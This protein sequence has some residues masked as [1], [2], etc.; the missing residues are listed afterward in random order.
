[1]K[2]IVRAAFVASL[3]L[4]AAGTATLMASTAADADETPKV[5]AKVGKPLSDAQKAI[6][7]NDFQ[8]ALA[9]VK[10]AQAVPDRTPFE[11]YEIN[12]FLAAV[13]IGLKDYATATTATEAAADSPAMPEGE[14]K[15][16]LHNAVLLATAAKQYQKA[17]VYGQQL[18]AIN[19]LDDS[20]EVNMAIAYYYVGDFPHAAQY[21]QMAIDAAK[22]AGK[23]PNEQALDIVMSSQA[24]QNNQAGAQQTLENLAVNYNKPESW[25]QLVD[26]ALGTKGARNADYLELLRLKMQV[27]GAM[28]AE[29]YTALGSV[30]NQL[31]YPTEAYNTLQKGIS[32]GKITTAQAGQTYTQARSGAALDE[33]SLGTIATQAERAKTGEQDIKLAEDYWGY[34]RFAD[35]ET[36]ARRA[37]SKGGLKDPGEG[38]VLLGMLLVVEGKYDEAIQTLAQVNGSQ[39]R[40]NT[41]HLWSLYAQAQK[42]QQGTP[43]QTP[44][45]AQQ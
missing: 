45:P 31:G 20:T 6:K 30:A 42:K 11:D 12:S 3:M 40:L 24:K 44:A 22:A 25:S 33:R 17:I 9:A 39:A 4:T 29:D 32:A 19:A 21:A 16:M 41:A 23:P 43:A 14:K 8:A 28:R 7:A 5:S 36:A 2:T 18:Q 35:A 26:L 37:I 13:A 10:E 27:P 1:M 15:G 34:G 38:P